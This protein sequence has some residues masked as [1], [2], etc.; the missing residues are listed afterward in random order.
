MSLTSLGPAQVLLLAGAGLLAGG[1]NAVAGAGSMLTLPVLM[2]SGLGA[3]SANATNRVAVLAQSLAAAWALARGGHARSVRRGWL[4]ALAGVPMA[5]LGAW[6]ASRVSE[7]VLRT[8]LAVAIVCFLGLASV[9]PGAERLEG[10]VPLRALWGL[11]ALGFYGGYLQ[12]GVGVLTLLYLDRVHHVPLWSA[13]AIK[14]TSA[15]ALMVVSLGVFW[16][17]SVPVDIVRASVLTVSIVLGAVVGTRLGLRGGE[18]VARWVLRLAL[19]AIAAR[20]LWEVAAGGTGA[21]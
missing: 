6:V 1:L 20:L 4:F 2:W 11:G 19:G 17:A 3:A 13:N 8:S 12:A 10:D 21:G 16:W 9:R 7:Q 18:R 15:V 5:A 14:H